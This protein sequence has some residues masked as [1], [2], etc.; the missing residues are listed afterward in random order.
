MPTL[1]L[2]PALALTAL[3]ALPACSPDPNDVGDQIGILKKSKSD[4]QKVKAVENLQKIGSDAAMKGM[5][6]LLKATPKP[7]SQVVAAMAKVFGET[8]NKDAV[9]ALC[10]AVDLTVGSGSDR[11]SQDAN[12]ANKEIARALG[13]IGDARAAPTLIKLLKRTSDNYVRIDTINALSIFKD[14]D[15]VEVLIDTAR[16]DRL[17]S[18][19]N[20][21]ALLALTEFDSE[22]ALPTFIWML[23]YERRGTSFF[24]ES[25]MGVFRLGDK[26][27]KPLLAVLS[28]EDKE[29]Y[30]KAKEEKIVTEAIVSKTAQVL[31]DLG[32]R[33]AIPALLKLLRYKNEE[34]PAGEYFVRMAAADALGRMRAKEAIRPLQAMLGDEETTAR[35]T[36]IRALFMIGDKSTASKLTNCAAKDHWL[37]RDVCMY[38]LAMLSPAKDARL[39]DAYEKNAPKLFEKDCNDYGIF[40]SIDCATEGKKDFEVML[41]GMKGYRTTIEV[42]GACQS[43][44]DCLAKALDHEEP[45]ARER[46]AYELGRKGGVEVVEP[47][48]SAIHRPLKTATDLAP[49]FAAV[50]G[51]DWA[52]RDDADARN[53]ARAAIPKLREQI[54]TEKKKQLSQPAAEDISRLIVKLER[55]QSEAL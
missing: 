2:V 53:K 32:S 5:L 29:L 52:T 30:A 21:K 31:G 40:G 23:F 22:K 6:D 49:R 35:Q 4:R 1:R 27:V 33:E 7:S 11:T 41:K 38:G 24:A 34:N 46:A 50:I 45:R 28:G 20:K 54:E 19:I 9:E 13:D 48:L 36:Y 26:A 44:T 55:G 16:D 17:E 3:L 39:F 15:A 14:P 47:L 8:K 43:E 37:L 25:A 51:L 42:V 18:F 10:E 12:T